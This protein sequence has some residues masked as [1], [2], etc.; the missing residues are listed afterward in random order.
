M[1][2]AAISCIRSARDGGLDAVL[3]TVSKE[4]DMDGTVDHRLTALGITLPDAPAPAANYVPF[5]RAGATL[6]VSGQIS[7]SDAGLFVGK[8]GAD[9]STSEAKDAARYCGLALI[10]QVKAACGGNLDK[11]RRVVKITGFVN[12]TP[13]FSEHPEVINGCSDLMVQVFGEAGRH[14]RAAVGAGSLPRGVQVE[15]EGVFEVD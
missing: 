11:V 5:V 6:Y 4:R 13:E 10:A 15:I 1:R 8:V 7:Q 12:A 2:Y 3:G 14:A 9:I